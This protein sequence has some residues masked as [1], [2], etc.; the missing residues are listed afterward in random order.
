[1]ESRD[2]KTDQIFIAVK[3]A[4]GMLKWCALSDEMAG[5]SFTIAAG[6]FQGSNS[7]VEVPWDLRLYFTL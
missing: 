1:M 5:L 4:A 2:L 3:T 6:P 7:R